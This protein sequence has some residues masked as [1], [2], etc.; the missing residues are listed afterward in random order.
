MK[1]KIK[2]L[3]IQNNN[4]LKYNQIKLKKV[5]TKCYI[6]LRF[7]QR[8]LFIAIVIDLTMLV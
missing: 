5:L 2:K 3:I 1:N 8:E 4:D 7:A 6:T